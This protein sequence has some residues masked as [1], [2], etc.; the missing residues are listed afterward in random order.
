MT[1]PKPIPAIDRFTAVTNPPPSDPPGV[2]T[3]STA[4]HTTIRRWAAS[5]HAEPATGEQTS[6]GPA[7]KT[8]KDDGAG[9]RFNFPGFAAF[10]PISWE[11]W[12]DNFDRHQLAF[13]YE[14][15]NRQEV[16]ERARE[17]WQLRG[18][19][20][21]RDQ[22]D[23]FRAEREFQQRGGG[24]GAPDVRYRF[25]KRNPAEASARSAGE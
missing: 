20:N 10:R 7:V 24:T 18:G 21:G 3:V 19:E 15:E 23:W 9:I 4:D 2:R 1:R 22:E 11:E 14:E 12:F 17:L 13:V 5:H 6:S 8:V 25:V 16:E